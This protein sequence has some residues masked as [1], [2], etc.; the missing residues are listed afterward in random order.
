M[1]GFL[2]F[3]FD[4]CEQAGKIT[5]E[6]FQKNP[7]T[8][9]K[10]DQSPVTIADRLSEKKIR[11]LIE[12]YYPDHAIVGEEYGGA[13]SDNSYCWF[14]DPI[15]GTRAFVQGVPIY[16]VMLGLEIS[17]EFSVGVINFPALNE[18]IGAARGEGCFWNGSPARVN[19]DA[20]LKETLFCHSGREY[21]QQFDRSKAYQELEDATGWQRTW[22][23]CYGHILV[24]TGRAGCCVDPILNAW[25]AGAIIPIV[26]EA[27]GTFTDWRGRKSAYSREGISTNGILLQQ[28]LNITSKYPPHQL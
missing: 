5:L 21:F 24:A 7:E 10:S 27:G 12:K 22:G 20:T 2:Q 13:K 18:I 19:R 8:E 23:D 16:G 14:I 26:E 4:A 9:T 15:D 25:D 3:A 11:E 6:Y 28:V 1:K 17:G